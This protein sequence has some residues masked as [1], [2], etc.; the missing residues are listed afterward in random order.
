MNRVEVLAGRSIGRLRDVW[1]L[2]SR[3]AVSDPPQPHGPQHSRLPCPLLPPGIC[4]NSCPL[5]QGN[6]NKPSAQETSPCQLAQTQGVKWPQ[7]PFPVTQVLCCGDLFKLFK[8]VTQGF[9]VEVGEGIIS[10]LT[11]MFAGCHSVPRMFLLL[12]I[13][14]GPDTLFECKCKHACRPLPLVKVWWIRW[15]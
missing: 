14:S 11:F 15:H 12:L 6:V 2:F 5:S 9:A 8:V 7:Y 10:G 4:P 13:K 1:L 3:S